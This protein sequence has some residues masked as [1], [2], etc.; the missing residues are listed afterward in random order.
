MDNKMNLI[1]FVQNQSK[2]R[3]RN[4]ILFGPAMSGKT[5]LVKKLADKMGAKYIDLLEDFAGDIKMKAAIDIFEPHD[6]VQYLNK[7]KE[8]ETLIIIDN[9]D[10]LFNTWD[11]SQHES[12]F[13][14]VQ[15]DDDQTIFC[16]VLQDSK[17]LK[18]INFRNS[19]GQKRVLSLYDI[20]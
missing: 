15:R 11:N 19:Q 14:F 18:G 3:Y 20:E 1:N 12:F 4:F 13:N 5:E 16:L 8:R 9:M 2:E 17:S 7:V 6:F 10:F